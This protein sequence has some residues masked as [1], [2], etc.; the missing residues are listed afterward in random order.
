MSSINHHARCASSTT[1]V[2]DESAAL[3]SL[4]SRHSA[5]AHRNEEPA[6]ILGAAEMVQLIRALKWL[7]RYNGI[8]KWH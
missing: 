4:V 8:N 6:L 7:M 2:N 3:G 5:E 1:M